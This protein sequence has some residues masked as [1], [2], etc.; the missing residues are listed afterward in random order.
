ME[1][2]LD[3]FSK[4]KFVL[5]YC[6]S[7]K[8]NIWP[9]LKNCPNCLNTTI[10]KFPKQSIGTLL[11]VS[12]SSKDDTFFGVVDVHNIKLIGEIGIDTKEN[13]EKIT[14]LQYGVK[15][16]LTHCGLINNDNEIFFQFVK[17]L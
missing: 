8:K 5:T 14:N 4:G 11:D 7:C 9:P 10:R 13:K 12:Y 17:I 15:V 1:N 3:Y 6:K 16:K 2:F